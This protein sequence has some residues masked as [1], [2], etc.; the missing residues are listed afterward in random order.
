M[1]KQVPETMRSQIKQNVLEVILK[2]DKSVN[3]PR[4]H[5]P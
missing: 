2:E 5:T 4:P 3:S 1:W